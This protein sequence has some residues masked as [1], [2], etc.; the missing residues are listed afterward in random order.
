MIQ[1]VLLSPVINYA[2]PVHRFGVVYDFFHLQTVIKELSFRGP[3][4][5]NVHVEL[6]N[7]TDSNLRLQ[8]LHLGQS[9]ADLE[10][11]IEILFK[12]REETFLVQMND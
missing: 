5:Q 6:G 9:E 1:S 8:D 3:W 2:K 4:C 12:I 10:E 11:A 7:V